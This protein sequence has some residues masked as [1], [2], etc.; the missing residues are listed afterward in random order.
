MRGAWVGRADG[1]GLSGP[2]VAGAAT[3]PPSPRTQAA[4]LRQLASAIRAQFDELARLHRGALIRGGAGIQGR[5]GGAARGR[6]VQPVAFLET[7]QRRRAGGTA[8]G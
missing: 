5:A 7:E 1:G 3:G 2:S 8:D 6:G 4:L